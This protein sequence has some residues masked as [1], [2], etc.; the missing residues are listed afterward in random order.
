MNAFLAGLALVSAS[1]MIYE[2]EL[3][4]LLS[5][6]TWYYLALAGVG[7]AMSG[8]TAGAIAVQLAPGFF[9]RA[10]LKR[11]MREAAALTGAAMPAALVVMLAV[12]PG[13]SLS[14]E[15]VFSFMI[16]TAAAA[17][18]FFFSGIVVCLAMTRSSAPIGRV[19]LA[20]LAGAAAGAPA[21]IAMLPMVGAPGAI[22]LCAAIS[23]LAAA[24]FAEPD[25]IAIRRFLIYGAACALAAFLNAATPY[26][27]APIW[28]KGQLDRRAHLLAETWNAVSRVTAT[29]P[30][31]EG[32]PYMFGASPKMP[33]VVAP[34][35]LLSV[36]SFADTP[37]Y[38]RDGDDPAQFDFLDYDVTSFAYMVKGGASAAIIGAGGGRDALAA[39][40]NGFSRIV[41]LE[42]NRAIVDMD[43]ARFARW[44]RLNDLPGFVLY[45]A[46]GRAYLTRT[47]EKFD[48]IQ[49]SMIDTEAA[50]AAGA[51][52]LAENSLY[53]VEAWT[54]FLGRLKPA[55]ILTFSR[56]APE[57][58]PQIAETLR[59]FALGCA[60]LMRHG[61]ADPS[62]NL[63]LVRAGGIGTLMVSKAPFD[64]AMLDR[65]RRLAEEKSYQVLYLPGAEPAIA[66]LRAILDAKSA[67]DLSG[68]R[69]M[70]FLS[71]A[72]VHDSSPFF[73]DFVRPMELPRAIGAMMKG[74]AAGEI[75]AVA[76]LFIFTIASLAILAGAFAVPIS[77]I[78]AAP[79]RLD[80]K[81]AAGAVYFIAIGLG[82]MC[83]EAAMMQQMTL[84][85]GA[86]AYS[87]VAVLGAL[88][89]FAGLGSLASD[90]MGV[91]ARAVPAIAAAAVLLVMSAAMLPIAHRFAAAGAAARAAA[92]LAIVA[93]AG[94]AMGGCFPV[95]LRWMRA[96]KGEGMLPW[97]WALNGGASV[98]ATFAA[99][100][101]SIQLSIGASMAFGGICYLLAAACLALPPG[102]RSASETR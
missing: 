47:Q 75:E 44:G 7:M 68:L 25:R 4:R 71:I 88:V 77:K 26:G 46:D 76:F 5:V 85:L 56:W 82:F 30:Y 98:A 69:F 12:P 84:M 43:L 9:D 87:L 64:S 99:L 50:T 83:A 21:A 45:A 32:D 17:M 29:G 91:G 70:G 90:R 15:I 63:A 42:V 102:D 35:I 1:T 62:R 89:L 96:M 60:A 73:F 57:G 24:A 55:G 3:T 49:A 101:I 93:P 13:L 38:R 27:I 2:V 66:E 78:A 92:T 52:T 37:L 34:Y 36:D 48:V 16:F 20:D 28:V 51:M 31:M 39:W 65:I 81:T 19:Y 53:T 59:I 95:G 74:K 33:P 72:P 23:F 67:A 97:M 8:M 18:P 11:R 6:V 22:L 79:V 54:I 58:T 10:M 41:G 40:R 80:W 94:L 61:V 86:P 14:L 100:L